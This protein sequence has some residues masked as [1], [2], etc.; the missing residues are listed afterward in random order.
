MDTSV[1]CL[2]ERILILDDKFQDVKSDCLGQLI[3]TPEMVANT[4]KTTMEW[5]SSKT[6]NENIRTN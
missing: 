1:Q 3:V 4:I 5:N 6:T 2:P